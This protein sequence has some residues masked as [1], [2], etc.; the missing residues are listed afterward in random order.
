MDDLIGGDLRDV[1]AKAVLRRFEGDGG[2]QT[3]DQR[4]LERHRSRGHEG[5]NQ[6]EH[7]GIDN[8]CDRLDEQSQCLGVE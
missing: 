2:K 4:Q 1:E 8:E 3:S 6:S 7:R 5:V